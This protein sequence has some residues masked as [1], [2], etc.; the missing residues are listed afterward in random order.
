MNKISPYFVRTMAWFL[1]AAL[2]MIAI[3]ILFQNPNSQMQINEQLNVES[4]GGVLG[5]DSSLPVN[6]N[7]SKTSAS[8]VGAVYAFHRLLDSEIEKENYSIALKLGKELPTGS[9][10]DLAV[11]TILERIRQ[12]T[13]TRIEKLG[14]GGFGE[15][16]QNKNDAV[17]KELLI[18]G[19]GL[20]NLLPN[21]E[22][23]SAFLSRYGL[24]RSKAEELDLISTDWEEV[25]NCDTSRKLAENIAIETFTKEANNK[26]SNS[27]TFFAT[28]GFATN[29]VLKFLFLALVA[30]FVGAIGEQYASHRKLKSILK[31]DS[32]ALE[33]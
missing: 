33:K 25:P 26:P 9:Q 5:N 19:N 18:V 32:E 30:G 8:F 12:I 29:K 3:A 28:M 7:S 24:L 20:I 4:I 14:S 15:E 21:N 13:D 16:S 10:R 1:S 17:I 2:F 6:T 11:Q 31:T 22:H 23:K 27:N